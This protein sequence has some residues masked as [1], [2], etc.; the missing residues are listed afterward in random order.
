MD[1]RRRPTV[2]RR[3]AVVAATPAAPSGSSG[4]SPSLLDHVHTAA[5]A[6]DEA[7]RRLGECLH[8]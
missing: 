6:I 7:G 5:A 2:I 1:L 8:H 4:T 3:R